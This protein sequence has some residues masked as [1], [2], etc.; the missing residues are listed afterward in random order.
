MGRRKYLVLL[1]IL[2]QQRNDFEA[3]HRVKTTGGFVKEENFGGGDQL[4]G[5]TDTSLLA[6]RNALAKGCADQSI[7]LLLETEAVDQGLDSAAFFV[8]QDRS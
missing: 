2:L 1:G 7:S 6:S 5:N 8:L 3:S 4:T